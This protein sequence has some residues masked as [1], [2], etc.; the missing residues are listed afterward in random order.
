MDTGT[1]AQQ[2]RAEAALDLRTPGAALSEQ[3]PIP[4]WEIWFGFVGEDVDIFH[5]RFHSNNCTD[6]EPPVVMVIL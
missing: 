2:V 5:L 1:C 6:F 4:D 3:A